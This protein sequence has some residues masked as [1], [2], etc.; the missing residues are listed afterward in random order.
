[1]NHCDAQEGGTAYTYSSL[2]EPTF[3]A[4]VSTL[5]W[6]FGQSTHF[7]AEP[8]RCN[9]VTGRWSPIGTIGTIA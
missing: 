1:M 7:D 9:G 2:S 8:R 5:L 4:L 6:Q 3:R